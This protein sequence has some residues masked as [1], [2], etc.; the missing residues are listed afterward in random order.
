ML[1]DCGEGTQ[2]QMMRYGT[3]FGVSRIFFTHLHAD[4]FLGLTGLLRTM[5][6]QGRTDPIQLFGPKGS[7]STLKQAVRLGA[8]RLPFPVRI[9]E[10][11][12]GERFEANDYGIESFEVDHGMTALGFA[13]VENPRLGR[14]D[15]A[16]AEALGVPYGPELGRLHR[17]EAIEV[18]GRLVQPSEVVGPARSGRRVVFSGDTRPCAAVIQSAEGADL[19]VHEAT[20]SRDEE[21]RARQTGHST[22]VEAAQVAKMAGVRR[23]I[24]THV[25]ARY[26]EMPG[27]LE[28]EA[29][30]VFPDTTVAHDGLVV[31]V[32]HRDEDHPA[33][34]ASA[35]ETHP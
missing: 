1:I 11:A 8:D 35:S 13:L 16:R 14:F 6:L 20:F 4:H 34:S 12:A 7:S 21:V 30:A 10:L 3:G 29:R 31:E 2:R 25:S 33:Q 32:P 27:A 5:G 24:L 9:V 19:L 15:P 23:L 22:A 17:G 18:D 28:Q 26:A